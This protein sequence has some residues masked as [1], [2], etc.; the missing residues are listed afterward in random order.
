MQTIT[1]VDICLVLKIT[2]VGSPWRSSGQE[3]V[4]PL[5]GAWVQSLVRELRSR[6]L[7][8]MAKKKKSSEGRGQCQ[9]LL[10]E[11][12]TY[13][14]ISFY[15]DCKANISTVRFYNNIVLFITFKQNEEM[16]K[17]LLFKTQGTFF[18]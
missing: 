14:P 7:H 16:H 12:G 8:G 11:E 6:M 3:S 15:I 13:S 10:A 1:L 5:Q 2:L 18:F 9:E 4:L 17:K